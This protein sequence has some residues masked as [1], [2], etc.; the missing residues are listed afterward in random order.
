MKYLYIALLGPILLLGK[1][2]L[3]AAAIPVGF[4]LVLMALDRCHQRTSTMVDAQNK[5][6]FAAEHDVPEDDIL[7]YAE[8]GS[9]EEVSAE[10]KVRRKL[11]A[12]GM[13][14]PSTT[15]SV[16]AAPSAVPVV[17][18]SSPPP[19]AAVA[20]AV[21]AAGANSALEG[22][23]ALDAQEQQLMQPAVPAQPATLTPTAAETFLQPVDNR[24]VATSAPPAPPQAPT[25][26][27]SE[28]SHLDDN[29][30]GGW[31]SSSDTF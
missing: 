30:A 22:S 7:S 2:P 16:D 28:I 25:E 10:E 6:R 14:V 20:A 11:I 21:G 15:E 1:A 23:L 12:A 24:D 9:V 8:D 5:E 29:F 27:I 18:L 17:S 26:R 3:F 19:F 13:L 4:A 31:A